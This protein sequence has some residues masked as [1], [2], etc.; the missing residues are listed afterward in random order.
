M[1]AEPA[2]ILTDPSVPASRRTA[3]SPQVTVGVPVYNGAD[4]LA[5]ALENIAAQSFREIEIVISDNASTDRSAEICRD[6]AAR[7]P[8]VRYIRQSSTMVAPY[9]FAFLLK[10][11]RAPYFMWAAHDDMRDLNFIDRLKSALNADSGAT[12][13]FGDVDLIF[14]DQVQRLDLG[15]ANKGRTSVRRL[16]DNA[17]KELFNIYGLWRTD[18]LRRVEWRH[19]EWWWDTPMM[20]AA[21]MTG[22]FIYVPGVWLRYRRHQRPAYLALERAGAGGAGHK[23]AWLGH[24]I[25]E[26]LVVPWLAVRSVSRV[27]GPGWGVAAGVLASAKIVQ[28]AAGLVW[29]RLTNPDGRV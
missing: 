2:T 22:D 4:T 29:R 1:R 10:E 20:M 28:R 24:R 23:I 13:A 27:A 7:D 26:I 6:F 5:V 9:N 18:A 16:A 17:F 21:A 15:F 8:R 25:G 12:L 14:D 11:A 3:T 19:N